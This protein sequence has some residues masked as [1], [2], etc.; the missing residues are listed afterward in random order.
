MVGVKNAKIEDI[1]KKKTQ[2]QHALQLPDTYIGSV[3]SDEMTFWIFDERT[4][5]M[6]KKT[7]QIVP[8]LYKIYDEAIVNA[9]DHTVRDKTCRTIKVWI[10]KE[11]GRITIY[12]D[13]T[14]IPVE[15]HKEYNMY[16]PELIFGNLLTSSTIKVSSFAQLVPQTPLP[17]LM[18]VQA[19]GPWKGPK[20]SSY[21]LTR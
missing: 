14:G 12:N 8:G 7:I 10:N 1:Y 17:L 16:V 9:G 6:I 11:E 19:T 5:K 4:N 13:G 2:H 15:I 21:F 3:E 18:R 20:I